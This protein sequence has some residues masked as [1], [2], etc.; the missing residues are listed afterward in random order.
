M[1]NKLSACFSKSSCQ[2][3]YVNLEAK[4]ECCPL[5]LKRLFLSKDYEN[6]FSIVA[7]GLLSLKR[8]RFL[9]LNRILQTFCCQYILI[10]ILLVI[11]P[12]KL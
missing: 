6:I 2:E 11:H 8:C 12:Q 7:G 10:V 3:I 9:E 1:T 4:R 5:N